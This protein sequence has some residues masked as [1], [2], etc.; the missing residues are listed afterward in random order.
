MK[1]LRAVEIASE[2]V[3]TCHSSEINGRL[4]HVSFLLPPVKSAA[5]LREHWRARSKRIKA[6][7]DGAFYA[8]LQAGAPKGFSGTITFTRYG[9][10][11]MDDDNLRSACKG[12]RD[13]IAK[14]IGVDDG[15]K[16]LKW[17]YE[18]VHGKPALI[19]KMEVNP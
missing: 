3:V 10:Q 12:V 19:V 15:S 9:W 18:Q 16:T 7:R 4:V 11:E 1:D 6:E 13:G 17:Q 2:Y 8:A 14:A 5:N